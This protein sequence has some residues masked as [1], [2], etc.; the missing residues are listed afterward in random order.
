[1]VIVQGYLTTSLDAQTA[2][3]LVTTLPAAVDAPY[4]TAGG[5]SYIGQDKA[6]Y[7]QSAM[8]KITTGKYLYLF[9]VKAAWGHYVSYTYYTSA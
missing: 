5:V 8:W 1:M 7:K 4:V 6:E 9:N 2:D 3:V